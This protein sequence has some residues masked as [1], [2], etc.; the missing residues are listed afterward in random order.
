MIELVPEEVH[1]RAR[2]GIDVFTIEELET[3][4]D[5]LCHTKE[6][7]VLASV[8]AG[9]CQTAH[10]YQHAHEM[11]IVFLEAKDKAL[12]ALCELIKGQAI[13]R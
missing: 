7:E 2:V 3:I 10:D 12:D 4:L 11:D 6:R 8:N 9:A 1:T 13:A 5:E